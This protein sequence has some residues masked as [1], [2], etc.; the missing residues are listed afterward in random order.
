MHF[1]F[2]H[3]ICETPIVTVN[4]HGEGLEE[5][6]I[7][8]LVPLVIPKIGVGVEVTLIDIVTHAYEVFKTLDIVLKDTPIV[9][10]PRLELVPLA[11]PIDDLDVR[12]K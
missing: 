5:P 9:K 4:T 1:V 12:V 10:R 8:K 3:I 11:K 2:A 6:I 7:P